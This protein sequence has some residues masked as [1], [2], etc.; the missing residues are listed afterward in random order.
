MDRVFD[1]EKLKDPQYFRD[2]RLDA[3]SDHRYYASLPDMENDIEE[4]KE[5]LNGLW[6][7]HYA[8]NYKSA[9]RGFEETDYCCRDR[10]YPD[11]R[12]RRAS[13]CERA[14]SLGRTR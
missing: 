12:V 14:V 10:S 3:H 6:K 11:G 1:Y 2:G 5:S 9:V 7:F 4:F 8:R 13:V